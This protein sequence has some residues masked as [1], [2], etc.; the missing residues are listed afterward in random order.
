[1][2]GPDHP[3]LRK[4]LEAMLAHQNETYAEAASL[5]AKLA[6]AERDAA[7]EE[8]SGDRWRIREAETQEALQAIGEEFGVR[9]GEPRTSGIRRVLTEQ[10]AALAAWQ[11]VARRSGV[12]MTCAISAPE[13]YGCTDCLNTGWDGGAPAGFTPEATIAARDKRIAEL[14]A[15]LGDLVMFYRLSGED[16]LDHF[17]RVAEQF[18]RDTSYLRPGKD[19]RLHGDEVRRAKWDEWVDAKV[20]RA[21]ALLAGEAPPAPRDGEGD[22]R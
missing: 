19:C 6:E 9:G 18:Y 13:P 5:R 10:R 2:S 11:E 3:L 1:L 21:R 4:L 22:A 15:G 14:T 12:C 17:E 20:A 16:A 7:R 8:L